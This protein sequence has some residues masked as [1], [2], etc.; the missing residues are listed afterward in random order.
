MLKLMDG[1]TIG[2]DP[3]LFVFDSDGNPVSAYAAGI[4]GSKLDP[5]L[6][7]KG[8][9]QRDGLAAE[10]NILPA[11]TF[12]EFEENTT[13]VIAD[14]TKMLPKGQ[15]LKAVASVTFP[16]KAFDDI[17][18]EDKVL[19][20]SADFDAWT[21]EM[22]D[23]PDT[24][25]N[26]FMRCAGGHLHYGWT[27]DADMSDIQHL[28]NCRDLVKQLDWY[29]GAWS[30]TKDSDANRRQLYG[31]AGACRYKPYGVEYRTLS[32]FWVLDRAM[33]E[34]I[35]NR[36][37]KAIE[38][39]ATKFM[40]DRAYPEWQEMLVQSINSSQLNPNLPVKF[41]Y[42]ISSINPKTVKSLYY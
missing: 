31:K 22:N 4:P 14:L 24:S 42:P 32:N 35:W 2:A 37:C 10:F 5:F 9:V 11:K 34:E 12:E 3:E 18:E 25:S 26:P 27:E 6:V 30:L 13:S 17:P 16:E 39:M 15:T 36:S 21:G 28:A 19:G 7:D 23:V 1:F 20:C 38:D 29:L 40:P 8:A 33:R 41:S